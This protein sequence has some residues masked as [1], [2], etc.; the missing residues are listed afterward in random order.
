M[1]H[2]MFSPR[3][4]PKSRHFDI[5]VVRGGVI[6][7]SNTRRRLVSTASPV[8]RGKRWGVYSLYHQVQSFSKELICKNLSLDDALRALP[9]GLRI[10]CCQWKG[11]SWATAGSM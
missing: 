5:V 4:L 6:L 1:C 8:I 9:P 10:K 3:R 2:S 7:T 11:H